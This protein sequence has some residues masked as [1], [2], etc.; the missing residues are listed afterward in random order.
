MS[1]KDGA[2][3]DDGDDGDAFFADVPTLSADGTHYIFTLS[4]NTEIKIPAY[5]SLQIGDDAGTGPLYVESTGTTISLTYPAGTTADDYAALMAQIIS[6]DGT[7]TSISTRADATGG[8]SVAAD[9][10]SM[11]VTVTPGA[12]TALL[13]VTLVGNDGSEVTRTRVVKP[14]FEVQGNTYIVYTAQG[15]LAWAQNAGSYNC[16]LAADIDMSGQTS[17]P[18]II[19]YSGTFDG[20]GHIISN[21]TIRYRLHRVR[22]HCQRIYKCGWYR[23]TYRKC[24]W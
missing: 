15:L 1:G 19:S 7:D 6:D 16:T 17:W 23:G 5:R 13:R 9:L 21:L 10:A 4:D 18:R 14:P 11:T 22:V 2:A 8:W 3:G 20:A 24:Y 12:G